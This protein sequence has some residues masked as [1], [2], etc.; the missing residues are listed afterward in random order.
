M[1]KGE[2][3]AAARAAPRRAPSWPRPARRAAAV[4]AAPRR[5]PSWPRP[6]RRAAARAAR[7]MPL[8]LGLVRYE[9]PAGGE[10]FV[11]PH[12]AAAP[13]SGV[14]LHV[15]KNGGTLSTLSLSGGAKYY[16]F[17]RA[18]TVCVAG[19]GY[20][21]NHPTLS[22]QH[23]VV[24]HGADD[25]SYLMDLDSPHGTC[26]NGE[27]LDPYMPRLLENGNILCFGQSTRKY[28][29]RLF[30]REEQLLRAGDRVSLS[31][32]RLAGLRVSSVGAKDEAGE[33]GAGASD[34][35]EEE[36]DD[37]SLN[38][39]A[40][41]SP[42]TL[43]E[44]QRRR[45]SLKQARLFS[46]LNA[47]VSYPSPKTLLRGLLGGGSKDV[48]LTEAAVAAAAAAL[49]ATASPAASPLNRPVRGIPTPAQGRASTGNSPALLALPSARPRATGS[50]H[51]HS[52][53][54][55]EKKNAAAHAAAAHAASSSATTASA[56]AVAV[57]AAAAAVAVVVSQAQAAA[58]PMPLDLLPA[59]L[60]SAPPMCALPGPAVVSAPARSRSV[61]LM[62]TSGAHGERGEGAPLEL[63][64]ALN[65][66]LRSNSTCEIR[67]RPAASQMNP[68]GCIRRRSTFERRVSFCA[69]PEFII[70]PALAAGS[71][72]STPSPRGDGADSAGGGSSNGGPG[73]P[74]PALPPSPALRSLRHA[75]SEPSP[76]AVGFRGL[77][78][79]PGR[80]ACCCEENSACC[81]G[82]G[83]AAAAAAA[84]ARCVGP[85]QPSPSA[86]AR[87][88]P[89][90]CL[91]KSRSDE[92]RRSGTCDG[93]SF[94]PRSASS[95]S[96]SSASTASS[97]EVDLGLGVELDGFG[98]GGAGSRAST[99]GS[100]LSLS[101]AGSFLGGGG[102]SCS[103]SDPSP[104]ASSVL[105]M[106]HSIPPLALEAA[107]TIGA[108]F[109]AGTV[110]LRDGRNGALPPRSPASSLDLI[111]EEHAP[112]GE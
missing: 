106:C 50:P 32:S 84:A 61:S 49:A 82:A 73:S 77:A 104:L 8:R 65:L 66:R 34:E 74:A 45:H 69:A 52:A 87:P 90:S 108:L 89:A 10:K 101:L 15:T 103:D 30:P 24:V 86:C 31:Y 71:A 53:S 23:A 99:L 38:G 98:P 47:R 20:V 81:C 13:H 105:D 112:P 36:D 97:G 12:W 39:D 46:G 2:S 25:A 64:H 6:A 62:D 92:M 21:I 63:E 7:G 96:I 22:R 79:E 48:E 110:P 16:M 100:S 72:R 83:R 93:D 57:A 109:S 54:F 76:M 78:G 95:T 88:P 43:I 85:F 94:L 42:G 51:P 26:V 29:V 58:A 60:Y 102:G 41:A 14:A 9:R 3:R 19:H 68:K 91:K 59:A 35:E 5:A 17:G 107:Y 28:V 67:K 27:R 18:P 1:S 4:R 80:G 37:D 55:S 75:T 70:E 111:M 11:V 44:R 56:V 40:E 33:S